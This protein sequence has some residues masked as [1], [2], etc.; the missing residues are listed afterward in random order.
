M[1]DKPDVVV[2]GTLFTVRVPL[3]FNFVRQTFL[4]LLIKAMSAHDLSYG[5]SMNRKDRHK[6][7]LFDFINNKQTGVG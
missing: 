3:V 6:I 2:K 7:F 4:S 5:T 1:Q